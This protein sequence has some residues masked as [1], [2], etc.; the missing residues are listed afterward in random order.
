MARK[1][2]ARAAAFALVSGALTFYIS[3]TLGAADI[4]YGAGA[5]W[6][7]TGGGDDESGFSRLDEINPA[8]VDRLKL[9]WS[10]DLDGETTLEATPLAVNGVLY[11]T[12]SSAK[13]YTV[14]AKT[15]K[16]LWQYDPEGW[17]EAPQKLQYSLPVNR[18]CAYLNGLVYVATQ[19]GRLVALDSKSGSV[20]WTERFIPKNS[21]LVSTGAPRAFNG[22]VIIGTSGGGGER[23]YVVAL[24][25]ETGKAL[26][27]FY[28]V[29][30]SPEQNA[31]DPAMEMAAK[32]WT[33]EFWKAGTNGTPWNG[34][35]YDP[36][37]D[38]IYIGT[39]NSDPYDPEIRSPGSGDNLFLASIVAIDAQTGKYIWHYQ[40]NPR[41]AWDFKAT[42]NMILSTVTIDGR[43]RKVLMQSPTNGF[44]Y[45]IDRDTG[46]L[47]SAEKTG[48]VTWASHI[49]L[50][51]GR[52]VEAPNIRY[53]KGE[54]VFWPSP[55]GTHN[56]QAMSFSPKTGLV[57][58]PY[59]QLGVR[60]RRS[61]APLGGESGGMITNI[62]LEPV[63]ADKED[64]KGKLLAWDPVTQKARWSVPLSTFWNGGTMVTGGG[65]V[66]QGDA[67]GN[68]SAYDAG[69]GRK[70]WNFNAGL[71]IVAAP[72]S[73]TVGGK[74]YVSVLVGYGG[75]I[76]Y[77]SEYFNR[78]WKYGHQ[79]RRLITFTLDGKAKLPKT[80]PPDFTV[81]PVDEPGLVIDE[82]QATIGSQIYG[83]RCSFCHGK[84][85]RG[86]GAPGPDLR[87]S[88]VA[89][90]E[91]S[92]QEVLL[93]G[94]LTERGMPMFADLSSSQVSALRMYVR[95]Q[96]RAALKK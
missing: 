11:F 3:P 43:P 45:V 66:F 30:G 58:I 17:Q 23:G 8:T 35:T 74:Q 54:S 55:M 51:T 38:R 96:A 59:M 10:L 83:G 70:L 80:A 26:W 69:I 18:G 71:G 21:K 28:T 95:Q 47:I 24:D 25:A 46:K 41:E 16:L 90:D 27:R 67:D 42:M 22:K 82:A 77:W 9:A 62:I 15:G 94:A 12:G 40:V 6:T 84:D 64:G 88:G 73:Y 7:A 31:G 53:E 75:G 14:D 36:E 60:V 63:S 19:D 34:L 93:K 2:P 48:K 87:E 4:S 56:W 91:A 1:M 33:G 49:D 13:V 78:G 52:P 76:A 37:L 32:T 29:P 65:L 5:N 50:R 39:G 86:S 89:L 57:Y 68:F 81:S 44:F 20:R 72:I 85:L 79:P 61:D 92:F